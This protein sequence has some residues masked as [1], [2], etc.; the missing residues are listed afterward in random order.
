MRNLLRLRAA[1]AHRLELTDWKQ[2]ALSKTPHRAGSRSW[3]NLVQRVVVSADFTNTATGA[4][5]LA[6]NTH[7]DDLSWRSRRESARFILDLV[8]AAREAEPEAAIVV[9]G[10]FNADARAVGGSRDGRRRAEGV[11]VIGFVIAGLGW[12]TAAGMSQWRCPQ[13]VSSRVLDI[14]PSVDIAFGI[15]GLMAVW[16]SVLQ[17]F[18]STR[19]WDLPMP[20]LT[21]GLCAALFFVL[22]VRLGVLADAERLPRPMLPATVTTIALGF[23]LGVLWEVFD[24]FGHTLIDKEIFVG[25]VDTIGDLV[26]GG[27]GALLAGF[28]VSFLTSLSVAVDCLPTSI[29]E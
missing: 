16:S 10:D 7:L 3:G 12:G 11:T 22:L 14:R 9:T 19:W 25:Y 13:G 24:W 26:W 4:R 5:L 21:N 6:F 27:A 29:L 1:G 15:V 2:R 28:C 17:I 18:I 23:S 20:L 8:V